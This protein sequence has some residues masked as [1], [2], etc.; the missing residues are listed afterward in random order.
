MNPAFSQ[1]MPSIAN[2]WHK[3]PN[4]PNEWPNGPN[5][6]LPNRSSECLSR[7]CLFCIVLM[8][9]SVWS[10]KMGLKKGSDRHVRN[11][12]VLKDFHPLSVCCKISCLKK[13]DRLVYKAVNTCRLLFLQ[14]FLFSKETL[15]ISKCIHLLIQDC[16]LPNIFLQ[17]QAE[18][19]MEYWCWKTVIV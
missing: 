3:R 2:T 8:F 16:K 17:S 1:W 7:K 11:S 18:A 15:P 4:G 13:G 14:I 5:L 19:N 6:L 12:N 9:I 10:C